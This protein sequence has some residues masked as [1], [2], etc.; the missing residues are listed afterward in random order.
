MM[1]GKRG[2][3]IA[4]CSLALVAVTTT[5]APA[6]QAHAPAPLDCTGRENITYGGLGL[7]SAPT[8]V[9]VDGV[10]HC[11]DPAGHRI[12]AQYHTEGT[13]TATCLLLASNRSREKLRY[14][15]GSTSVIAYRSGPSARLLGVNTAVLDGVV[16]SGRGKGSTARK[17]IQ[18]LPASLPT[19]CVLAGGIRHTTAF[20]HLSIHP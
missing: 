11:A 4:L 1:I 13:T 9:T 3:R 20:T 12:T 6:G 5:W 18:T 19:D 2:V 7:S 15:D 16:I 17:V 10:Y 14:A 8:S